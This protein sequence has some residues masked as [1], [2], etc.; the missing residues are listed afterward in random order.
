[1]TSHD[2]EITWLG[3]TVRFDTDASP[4]VI[5]RSSASS[6]MIP[7]GIVSRRHLVLTWNGERWDV[8]DVSTHGTF[9]PIGVK[10]SR[11]WVIGSD[12]AV[13]LGSADGTELYFRM[14][15]ADAPPPIDDSIYGPKTV[16]DYSP[17]P[18][19]RNNDGMLVIPDQSVV[20]DADHVPVVSASEQPGEAALGT[21]ASMAADPVADPAVGS[22]ADSAVDSMADSV[23]DSMADSRSDMPAEPPLDPRLNSSSFESPRSDLSQ[24]DV[25]PSPV[26]LSGPQVDD[27]GVSAPAS[28]QEST[29]SSA[30]DGAVDG[31]FDTA[32]DGATA[33]QQ[34]PDVE[35]GGQPRLVDP[36]SPNPEAE[37]DLRGPTPAVDLNG[38]GGM[39]PPPPGDPLGD[40]PNPAETFV[41]SSTLRLH[42]DGEDYLFLPGV[43][44]TI[45]RDP[46]CTVVVDE[47]HTL[48]SRKHLR[49]VH[50]SGKWWFE[51]ISSKGS[52]VDGRTLSGP[53]KAEGAFVVELGDRIGGTPLRVVTSG[54]H[55]APRNVAAIAVAAI[56]GVALLLVSFLAWLM[57]R[58]GADEAA[59]LDDAKRSTVMLLAGNGRGS[60][61]FVSDSLILTNQHVAAL[62]D[63]LVVAV[64]EES[65]EPAQIQYIAQLV[66][67]HPFLDLAVLKVTNTAE[68]NDSGTVD[69]GPDIESLDVPTLE[70]GSSDDVTLGDPIF[71]TG[72][73]G[74]L[75]VAST[76]DSGQLRLSPVST[77]RGE[78][79]NFAIWPGCS[80]PEFEN[81]IPVDAPE[82]V[83]CD[84][85]GDVNRG[86]LIASFV[87]GEGASGSPVVHNG[88]VVAVVFAGEA[89]EPNVSRSITS[90]AFDGWLDE[91]LAAQ[92]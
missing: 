38:P 52:Y 15:A 42:V 63:Q 20:D 27:S 54:E 51:D 5:G 67:S 91:I 75:A 74:R 34:L 69:I 47:H 40:L 22:V 50:Q 41:E 66:E 19:P 30:F 70:V 32:F 8:E 36:L 33:V 64:S 55:K 76:D 11:A 23:A 53:Y 26:D 18:R 13:R 80:N 2:I 85:D 90:E 48:V 17:P 73:P 82:G 6:I 79:A 65:D 92:D 46:S 56:A 45:G 59:T 28:I 71:S 3:N 62:A 77:S 16:V 89:A 43:E 24:V 81:F 49:V 84:P 21:A 39:T 44:I 12:G 87:S 58:G 7:D 37:L 88:K 72:F 78:A 4:V 29:A 10:L 61:F 86:V 60:G 57:F 9:D 14:V 25:A 68:V 83:T 31:A 1:M 35:V